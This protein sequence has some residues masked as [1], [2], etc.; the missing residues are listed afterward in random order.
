MQVLH[1]I[2]SLDRN[3]GGTP[4]YMRLLANEL[5]K[6]IDIKIATIKSNNPIGMDPNVT[7]LNVSKSIFSSYKF[8][9][10]LST[11]ECDLFH[12]NGIW[13][14]PTHATANIARRRNIPYIISPHGM[15][16]PWA[17]NVGKLK[18]RLALTIYQCE[19]L[20]NASCLHAT[21]QMEAE[22]IRRIGFNNP[23]A[24]IPN[25]IDLNEYP[26]SEA[27]LKKDRHTILFLSRIHKKKGIELL[28]EAWRRL[29]NNLR[30][31]WQ[32]KII[33]NGESSYIKSLQQIIMDNRLD[34][35]IFLDGPKFGKDKV[36]SYHHADLF[37][38][39]TFSENFGIVVAEAMACG[40]P[41]ITTKGTPWEDINKCNA[42]S[43]IDIGV[44]PLINALRQFMEISD[45]ER[46]IIGKNGRKLIEDRFSIKSVTLQMIELYNW[47]L[48][49]T[50]PPNFILFD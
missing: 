4:A 10:L 26:I 24:I 6:Y 49:R 39:P 21:A 27:R 30:C 38:L 7:V 5:I 15:L 19:D 28:I 2:A 13:Q 40:I 44:E 29:D 1:S 25:G 31:D 3:A 8:N 32:I 22:S 23:I 35:E 41:V 17:L 47:I 12:G 50:P 33:G 36:S 20:K 11:I 42:G 16:E 45:E 48:G 46:S 34:N 18:K 37:V 43:W 9:N 14:Y